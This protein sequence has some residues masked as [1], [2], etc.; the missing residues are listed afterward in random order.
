MANA[1]NQ[2]YAYLARPYAHAAFQFA[3]DNEQLPTW[4]AFLNTAALV[5]S[6]KQTVALLQN[7]AISAN[8][9]QTLFRDVLGSLNLNAEQQNFLSVLAEHQ[10]FMILPEIA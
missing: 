3:H 9:L 8:M 4:K 7:P 10:R 5:A 6:D 2:Q 1:S